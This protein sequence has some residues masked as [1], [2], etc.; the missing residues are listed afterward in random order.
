MLTFV[1]SV[2]INVIKW[3][4]TCKCRCDCFNIKNTIKW[5]WDWH[6][7]WTWYWKNSMQRVA[8][9]GLTL[10]VT[11]WNDFWY[12]RNTDAIAITIIIIILTKGSP[13]FR[14]EI[15]ISCAWNLFRSHTWCVLVDCEQRATNYWS[16]VHSL[17]M[18]QF[19][20]NFESNLPMCNNEESVLRSYERLCNGQIIYRYLLCEIADKQKEKKVAAQRVPCI[21]CVWLIL[22]QITIIKA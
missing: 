5:K 4:V 12:I 1:H 10:G 7:T 3:K 15:F 16:P 8:L 13:I 21:V 22:K 18:I 17:Q 19:I 2:C 14:L 20:Q 11:V 9:L 6:V